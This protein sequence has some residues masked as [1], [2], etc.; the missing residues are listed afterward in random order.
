MDP[1]QS[2]ATTVDKGSGMRFVRTIILLPCL[3]ACGS[4]LAA[5]PAYLDDRSD[6]A[7]LVKSF[8]NAIN[9]QEYSRA[10][11]Y[12]GE[13]KPAANFDAFVKGF[14][15]TERVDV[16]TGA[17]S[18]E[19]AAGSQFYTV[20][21]AIVAFGKSG[22]QAVFAGCY[23][24]RL[25]DP[26]IQEPPFVSLHIETARM[27]AAQQ[28]YQERLPAN[29]G[30]GPPAQP[31]DLALQ[32]AAKLFAAAHGEDCPAAK[33]ADAP[34]PESYEL[35]LPTNSDADAAG[36]LGASARLMRFV[37]D[38]TASNLTHAY[39]LS[40][41]GSGVSAVTFATPELDI[42][43][44]GNDSA[45]KLEGVDIIGFT[46]EATLANSIFD[47]T[48]QSIVSAAKWRGAGDA[49]SSGTWLFRKGAFSLVHFEVDASY[50]GDVNPQTVLDYNS[51]P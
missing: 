36:N 13:T 33:A 51:A 50:D 48:T 6:A 41:P 27:A 34:A 7:S 19:G 17:V 28:P 29:C 44:A 4:A 49:S 3:A 15:T 30:D 1:P 20:P 37:C 23:T 43:N 8:Y 42:H 32:E 21:V 10:W 31:A 39:Y 38:T 9:R 2:E 14:A 45:G 25:S 16:L 22:G 12:F 47:E 40:T 11:D 26:R 5:E 18:S 24:T 46:T 35:A